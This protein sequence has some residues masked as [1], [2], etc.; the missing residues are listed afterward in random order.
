MKTR[1]SQLF[2]VLSQPK[3]KAQ[4]KILFLLILLKK[5]KKWLN[6]LTYLSSIIKTQVKYLY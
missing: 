3:I 2:F 6:M 1:H 5:V 4:Y